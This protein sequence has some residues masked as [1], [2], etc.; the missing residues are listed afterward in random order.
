[1]CLLFDFICL[2]LRG[3]GN[4]RVGGWGGDESINDTE[5]RGM[6]EQKAYDV[7]LG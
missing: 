2:S 7:C 6:N 5:Y 1:M 4:G 3:V